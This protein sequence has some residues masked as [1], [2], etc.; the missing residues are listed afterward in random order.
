MFVPIILC[1]C[2]C[3]EHC[4]GKN[5]ALMFFSGYADPDVFADTASKQKY[6]LTMTDYSRFQLHVCMV[7]DL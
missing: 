4:Y 5:I 6:S 1:Y 2:H 7:K 3:A